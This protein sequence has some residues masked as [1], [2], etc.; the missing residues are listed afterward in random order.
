MRRLLV[1]R[2]EPGASATVER[3]RKLGLD[4]RS[5]P[6]FEIEP[7]EWEVP[8]VGNF[9]GLLLTSAN[10]LRLGG[11]KLRELRGLPV[12][13][14]GDATADAAREA[15]FDVASAGDSGIE[16]LLGSIDADLRLLHLCG[17][18]RREAATARQAITDVVLYRSKVIECPDLSAATGSVALVHSPRA[19]ERFAELVRDRA[20]TAIAGISTAAA[21]AVG[22]GWEAVEAASAPNDDALLALAARLCNK[23]H[24]E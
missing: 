24:P 5:I 2:P 18:E 7:I 12:Y 14:V 3:A 8:E 9:D 23:P 17:E 22:D 6:L 10:A 20:S 4:A 15:G 21:E 19:G 1:L 13:A 11:D 16:R